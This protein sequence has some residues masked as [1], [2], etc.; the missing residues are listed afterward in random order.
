MVDPDQTYRTITTI[1]FITLV[2]SVFVFSDLVAVIVIVAS[3][4]GLALNWL[5]NQFNPREQ[6]WQKERERWKEGERWW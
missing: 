6:G 3:V 5:S 4:A 2:I 1:L